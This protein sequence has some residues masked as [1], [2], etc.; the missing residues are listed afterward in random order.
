MDKQPPLDALAIGRIVSMIQQPPK[1]ILEAARALNIE[2]GLILNGVVHYSR[3][4]VDTIANQI[5]PAASQDSC[6]EESTN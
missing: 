2:P 1:R 6:P 5:Y 3:R 4:D